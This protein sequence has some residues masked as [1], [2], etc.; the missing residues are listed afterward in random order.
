M[1]A[2]L[3]CIHCILKK[4]GN[5]Y[6]KY[7]SNEDKRIEFL[8][9]I[10]AIMANCDKEDTA[11][12]IS[13]KIEQTLRDEIGESDIYF[14]IKKKY[15]ELLLSMENEILKNIYASEDKVLSALKYAMVGNFIDFGAMDDVPVDKLKELID[16][17]LNKS[18][19][20]MQYNKFIKD[21]NKYK[22]IVYITDNAGEIVF[23]KVFIKIL[24]EVY[25]DINI[26]VMVRGGVA[27][28]DATI[29]DAEEI[30]LTKMVNVFGSGAHMMG[31][32]LDKISE[33][34]QKTINDAEIIIAKGQGNFETLSGC[35]K[36][37][38]YA[39]LCKCDMFVSLF[40][41]ERFQGVF[42]NEKDLQKI[43]VKLEGDL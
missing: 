37:V 8:K 40:N 3:R 24:K 31:T 9:K 39:F 32:Q 16:N 10:F 1:K 42:I 5:L 11:A 22:N 4:Y 2:K 18:I 14:H 25:K 6:N 19:D 26:D 30:G 43:M 28:N 36:N 17:A 23:D 7:E 29:E 38:Y 27:A 13:S 12:Y 15:N 34:A 35:S 21:L 20:M 41:I 33:K